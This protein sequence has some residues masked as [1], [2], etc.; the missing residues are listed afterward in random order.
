MNRSEQ[1]YAG[2]RIGSADIFKQADIRNN[3]TDMSFYIV[4]GLYNDWG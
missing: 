4:S 1:E 3:L 2:K